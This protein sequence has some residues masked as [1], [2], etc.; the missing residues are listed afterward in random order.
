MPARV[1][2]RPGG[3]GRNLGQNGFTQHD[4]DTATPE[5][6]A[7]FAEARAQFGFVPNLLRLMAESPATLRGYRT[8]GALFHAG[9]F[10]P[11]ERLLIE[12]A[13]SVENGCRYCTA[14][15]TAQ[16]AMAGLA[17]ADVAAVRA[18]GLPADSRG[19]ALVTLLRALIR[20]RGA[21]AEA[22]VAAFLAAGFER[23]QVLEL[24]LGIAMK[25]ISNYTN[26]LVDAPLDPAV[27]RALP[28]AAS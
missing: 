24:V 14:A 20:Q 15:H 9:S 21:V 2:T 26:H 1:Y 28:D 3:R 12:L 27:A 7:L 10:A 13:A 11:R 23:A 22:E 16:A 6:A 5:V 4:D 8:L 25:T 18:G 17:P 19:A